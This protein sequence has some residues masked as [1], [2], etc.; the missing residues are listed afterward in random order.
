MAKVAQSIEAALPGATFT[1]DSHALLM[2]IYKDPTNEMALRLDAAKAAI[3]Y[4][5]PRLSA[6][7]MKAEVDASIEV[8]TIELVAPSLVS[9]DHAAH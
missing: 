3:G 8:S 1:G 5:K 9:D 2:A 7:E 4:E 6:V